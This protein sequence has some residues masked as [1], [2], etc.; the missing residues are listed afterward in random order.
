MH[1]L[2][3]KHR[4]KQ[5]KP[6]V[7]NLENIIETTFSQKRNHLKNQHFR[8]KISILIWAKLEITHETN[9]WPKASG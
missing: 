3:K 2:P 5:N 6:P 8:P 9:P 1:L 7:Q 4:N